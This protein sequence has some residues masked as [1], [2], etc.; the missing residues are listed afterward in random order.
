[1]KYLIGILIIC[2]S[3]YFI[4]ETIRLVPIAPGDDCYSSSSGGL[5]LGWLDT[6]RP[7]MDA[8]CMGVEAARMLQ[9]Q[10]K[11]A[12]SLFVVCSLEGSRQAFG[13]VENCLEYGG[14]YQNAVDSREAVEAYCKDRSRKWYRRLTFTSKRKYEQCVRERL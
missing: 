8:N 7:E 13:S 6:K 1:M 2:A 10:G 5:R 3:A 9:E 11:E 14:D 12:R 4:A